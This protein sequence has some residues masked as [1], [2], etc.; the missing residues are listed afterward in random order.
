MSRR[1]SARRRPPNRA[2]IASQVLM[3]VLML[4]AI[5]VFRDKIGTG[6]QSF[7][8]AVSGPDVAIDVPQPDAGTSKE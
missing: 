5:L 1:R 3:L 6:A 7:I 4:I 8:D 2:L